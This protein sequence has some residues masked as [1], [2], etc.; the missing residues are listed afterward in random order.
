VNSDEAY[1]RRAIELARCA[2]EEGE[3]PVGAVV[4]V[5]GEIVGEG[6]NRPIKASDPS[7]HA[8]IQALR[9]ASARLANY[10]LLDSTLYVTLEPC[11]MCVGAMF[12]ARVRRVVFGAKDPKTGA[13]GSVIDLFAEEKL[14]HHASVEGGL[15]AEEC[16]ELLK[17]FFA[18]RR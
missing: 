1:M 14:N 11:P 13:A 16:G 8:E 9:A 17:K 15:L 18:A 3:V 4:T 2:A 5:D 12:H 7:A 10:R 6:W